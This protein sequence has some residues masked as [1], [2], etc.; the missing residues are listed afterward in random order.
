MK[1]EELPK[2]EGSYYDVPLLEYVSKLAQEFLPQYYPEED[3]EGDSN[4]PD[5]FARRY[6]NGDI[7]TSFM[8]SYLDN[9]LQKTLKAFG[10]DCNKFWY[11]CL[12]VKDITLD[13]CIDAI[14]VGL[15]GNEE[16]DALMKGIE[17]LDW[18]SDNLYSENLNATITFQGSKGK[19]KINVANNAAILTIYQSLKEFIPKIES[20]S[21]LAVAL[22]LSKINLDNRK[23]LGITYTVFQYTEYMRFFLKGYTANKKMANAIN[24]SID[25]LFLISR[26]IYITKISNDE[27]YYNEYDEDYNKLNFLKNNIR[28]YEGKDIKTHTMNCI[29]W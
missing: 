26:L 23:T 5:I 10:I 3:I 12:F 8:D 15:N 27:R 19:Q 6:F 21:K 22:N 2:I 4:A 17:S 1:I 28:K 13:K 7:D 29:Y 25:K 16:L 24:C 11:L 9:D 20:N 14:S 18:D